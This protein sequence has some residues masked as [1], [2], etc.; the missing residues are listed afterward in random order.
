MK[1]NHP[2]K[3]FVY[4]TKGG[5]VELAESDDKNGF[6]RFR[7]MLAKYD[8]YV[9]PR[10]K[11]KTMSINRTLADKF[12]QNFNSKVRG[13]IPAPL[14]HPQTDAELADQ[15]RGELMSVE[16]GDDGLYGVIEVRDQDT[17][18]KIESGLIP[19]VSIAFDD[20][21]Q[22]KK[23]GEWIGPTLKHVGLVVNPYLKGMTPFEPA[24][25]D[26]AGAAVLFSDSVS[27]NNNE[28]E[29]ETMDTVDIKNDR[30]FDVE[31]TYTDADNTEQKAT[32]KAGETIT[33]PQSQ[34]DSVTQQIT[35]AEDPE[36][37]KDKGADE[38]QENVDGQKL[39]DEQKQKAKELSDR[40]A[41]LA[42]KEAE[43]A[44]KEAGSAFSTLLSEGK[45]VPA[46]KDAYMAL[47]KSGSATVEL[48]DGKSKTVAVLLSEFFEKTPK[49]QYLSEQGKDDDNG[50]G[51]EDAD[52]KITDEEKSYG[53]DFGNTP[54]EIAE[55]KKSQ[56]E[57]K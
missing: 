56:E 34:G 24:L 43:M 4:V 54:E 32:V 18:G 2:I 7:K 8:D 30:D 33:V 57:S 46:Q 40:E 28:E 17:A 25:S 26:S 11:S 10:D 53:E 16:A 45:V 13:F 37:K 52:V 9:D 23:T 39:S 15:N 50:K 55:Y 20:D 35:D 29:Q 21:Y 36:D 22:D 48:S 49:G 44:E 3:S 51:G 12:V 47:S 5:S 1:T 27:T 31:V 6:K 19:D 38:D 41:A 14:G 42:K